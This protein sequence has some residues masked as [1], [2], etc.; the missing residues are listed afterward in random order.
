MGN[1]E[2]KKRLTAKIKREQTALLIK[3]LNLLL[4]IFFKKPPSL[5]INLVHLVIYFPG[6][7]QYLAILHPLEYSTR[8]TARAGWQLIASTW[9]TG[10]AAAALGAA[11]LVNAESPWRAC[12][13][14][15][16]QR[17]P[18]A[19]WGNHAKYNIRIVVVVVVVVVVDDDVVVVVSVVVVVVV[20]VVKVVVLVVV[21]LV[22]VVVVVVV[23]FSGMHSQTIMAKWS[24]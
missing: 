16:G 23:V 10:S 19:G 2:A 9:L 6:V 15:L 13:A 21:V 7:D 12:R 17:P 18:P 8:M 14:A 22:V 11:Q 4:H 24:L 1:S 3:D 20:E 5:P